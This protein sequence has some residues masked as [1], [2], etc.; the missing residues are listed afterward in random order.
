MEQYLPI[1]VLF[2]LA[3]VFGV[4]SFFASRL[5]SPKRSTP[6]KIAPFE[7]GIIS[8]EE[9]G[10]KFSVKFFLV[11]MLFIVFDIEIIFLYPW[12][13]ESESLG[14]GGYI[15]ILIFSALVFESFIYIISKGALEWGPLQ[16][17]RKQ[18]SDDSR[19]ANS[20]LKRVGNRGRE[21]YVEANVES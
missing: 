11:A 18:T 8:T 21:E 14:L 13:V 9:T 7:C 15:S 19:D 2:F 3:I 10:E 1:V 20:T 5:L 6:Q 16:I 4:L 12:A 17:S